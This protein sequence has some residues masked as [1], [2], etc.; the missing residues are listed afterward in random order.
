MRY[1]TPVL[2]TVLA[3]SAHSPVLHAEAA[4]LDGTSKPNAQPARG[5]SFQRIATLA[6][7]LNNQDPNATTV[8]EITSVTKD[9]KLLVYTDSPMSEIG[10]VDLTLPHLPAGLGKLAMPGEPTSVAVLGNELALVAVDTSASFV[11]PS[12]QLVIVNLATRA[13][14]GQIPLAGQPDS[15][16]ISPDGKY[17][18]IAIESQRDEEVVVDGEEGGM[19]QLPAGSLAIVDLCGATK[20]WTLR[21]VDLTG[22]A[23]YAPSD[24]EPEFVDI[25]ARNRA[26]V[27]LQENNHLVIVDLP[28]GTVVNDFPAGQVTLA[29]VDATEDG[30]I[31]LTETIADVVREPDAVAWV[32]AGSQRYVAT[33]NEGDLFGGSRGFTL[34]TEQGAVAF[35]SGSLLEALAV[36]HGHY[37]DARSENKGA[38]PEAIAFGRFGSTDY[39]FVGS[40]RGSF[41][42]VFVIQASGPEFVQLLP[43]PHGPEGLLLIPSRGL[44]V[45]SGE[46]DAP[47]YGVR[48]TIMVYELKRG[49]PT[50]PQIVAA[51][52]DTGSP[53]PWSALS[54]MSAVPDAKHELVVVTDAYSSQGNIL[55]VNT[56]SAPAVI[57]RSIAVTG[58]SDLDLEG[59]TVAADGTYWLASEGGAVEPANRLLHTDGEGHVLQE[60]FLPPEIEACRAASTSTSTLGA[61]FEGVTEWRGEGLLLVAQQRGWNFTTPECEHLDDDPTDDDTLEPGFTRLWTYDQSSAEWGHIS[62]ELEPKPALAAWVGLSEITAVRDGFVLIE[63]DNVGGDFATLKTLV[64]VPTSALADGL[65]TRDEKRV[66]NLLPALHSTNGWISDKPEG[67]AVDKQG[68]LFVVTDNDGLDDW[69]GETWFLRLG[70]YR[71]LF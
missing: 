38:E 48:S 51:D 55:K 65:I 50:Y 70:S 53:V 30:V 37:P 58:S 57:T 5:R 45:V 71:R 64:K 24:P 42:A 54:G 15:I 22:M 31:S 67:V 12:G 40:E 36:R 25:D 33:A 11:E 3:V 14:V 59:I 9:G 17:A 8:A 19:P 60:V 2:V 69:S 20:D 13:I 66:F 7:T 16:K 61:G 35:D 10:F 21:Y 43:A 26:V 27:S 63:R 1:L 44:L 52:D 62:Y 49:K 32:L 41:I 18:A 47:P 4:C 23:L 39:L 46:E 34:F 29:G 68:Q 6:N 28:S 56:T